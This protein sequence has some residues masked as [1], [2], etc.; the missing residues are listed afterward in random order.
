MSAKLYSCVAGCERK[1]DSPKSLSN[2]RSRCD[3][4]I[5]YDSKLSERSRARCYETEPPAKRRRTSIGGSVGG[6]ESQEQQPNTAGTSDSPPVPGAEL[7]NTTADTLSNPTLITATSQPPLTSNILNRARPATRSQTR[8]LHSGFRL[9]IDALPEGPSSNLVPTDPRLDDTPNTTC[10]GQ[11]QEQPTCASGTATDPKLPTGT[12][13]TEPDIFGR[14]R[15]YDTHPLRIP[16]PIL[17]YPTL[18]FFQPHRKNYS[19]NSRESLC[20]DVIGQPGFC[21]QDVVGY[22][23]RA[24][25]RKLAES[26]HTW[27]TLCPPSKGWKNVSIQLE[28]PPLRQT[29]AR[30]QADKGMAV[31]RHYLTV[32]GLRAQRLTDIVYKAFSQNNPRSFHYTPYKAL[33]KPLD[34]GSRPAM[35]VFDEIYS[36]PSMLNAHREVQRLKI[37]DSG[38]TRPRCVAYMMFGSDGTVLGKGFS[39]VK[40][41]PIYAFFGNESKY[42]R[43]KPGSNTC[44]HVA[45][46]PLLPDSA[47]ETITAY[48]DGKPPPE[49][50]ITH[51]RRRV[52]PR[53]KIHS[54]DYPEKVTMATIRNLG[55]CLCPRCLAKKGSASKLGTSHDTLVRVSKRR[56]E[57]T[58]RI[59]KIQEAQRLIYDLG[60]SVQSKQV[61]AL[62]Q[63]ESYVPT[64]NAFSRRLSPRIFKFNIFETFVVDQLHEIELGV[65]KSLFQHLVRLL[66]LGGSRTIVEFNKRFR[67]V[68]TF[69][70]RDFEDILQCCLPVFEGL[71]PSECDAP[72]QR[73][74]FTFA[75][76]HGL[77]K[78]CRHTTETLKIMKKL[79]AKLGSEL[80]SFAELTQNM[81]VRETP[82]EYT[83]RKKRQ[84]S[85]Q[86]QRS[87]QVATSKGKSKASAPSEIADGRRL[88]FFNINTYKVHAIG[89]YIYIIAEFGTTDSYSTQIYEL[90]HRFIK[91]Q[92]ERTNKKDVVEQMTQ[93]GD[94]SSALKR[95]E[96]ELEQRGGAITITN[97]ITRWVR[98]QQHDDAMKFFIP[99]LKRYF[100][101]RFLGNRDHPKFNEQEI[102][103]VRFHQDRMYRHK[104][105]R[106]N[107]TS[108]DV[109]RQQDLLN[110]STSN[111][112]ILLHAQSE[113]GSTSPIRSYMLRFWDLLDSFDFVHPSDIIRAVHLIPDFRSGSSGTLLSFAESVA[114]DSKDPEHWD[115][116][117]YYV[118]RFVDRDMLMR[119]LGGGIGHY[120]YATCGSDV[121]LGSEQNANETTEVPLG[122]GGEGESG[123]ME[124]EGQRSEDE[125]SDGGESICLAQ[126][127]ISDEE[128]PSMDDGATEYG[129]NVSEDE[130]EGYAIDENEDILNNKIIDNDQGLR[131]KTKA[132]ATN[133]AV[134]NIVFDGNTATGIRKYG[135]IVDQG[136]PTTLGKAG[137]SVAMSG[138]SF[139]TNNI[140]VTSNAQRVAVNC[141]S[142][143]TGNWDWSK[144]KVTGGKA[145]K[146]YN[147]KN[148][149]SGSY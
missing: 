78:L 136:Y 27:N 99:Q 97:C 142:K 68:P 66:H 22:N 113:D 74:L 134:T 149:K 2:H 102:L 93:I 82:D 39:H 56:V 31:P 8:L 61:E 119:Y 105:L 42:Q 106:I 130:M 125:R 23:F 16:M 92:F 115:W 135:V 117:Y 110:P 122:T 126:D 101:A 45:H 12:Y 51:L 43:C 109:L 20:N 46:I 75:F 72:V 41:H 65:W 18:L 94:V 91:D 148:I 84:A 129:D 47:R 7:N 139:G 137:N 83:R 37:A 73:L 107:Y 58:K 80:R 124:S 108:Y 29:K 85:A 143:C 146:M 19:L 69:A 24:L 98:E 120:L 64:L 104:T 32:N 71:L 127:D 77:A 79:T 76:W 35:Q 147:Y 10:S 17:L 141:G 140:A 100:L 133:A 25:D 48:H 114:H 63:A 88:C 14:Y 15:I 118:N 30:T 70:A 111:R 54:V 90:Q 86:A 44:F 144:L 21:P 131:I 59:K 34:S 33:W 11:G 38:C 4:A 116:K 96:L 53:I 9:Q 128:E 81:N 138:I 60:H 28:I 3:I 13:T 103:K 57:S 5:E 6:D 50:L 87:T 95:M 36:S 52:F 26:E 40:G 132:D 1:L 67:S 145:G 121:T 49:S 112:F 62:L 55:V 89:D 123:N